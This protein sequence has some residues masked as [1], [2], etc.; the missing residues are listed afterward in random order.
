MWAA[1]K[2]IWAVNFKQRLV[3]AGKKR[4]EIPAVSYFTIYTSIMYFTG[5]LMVAAIQNPYPLEY[6][7]NFPEYKCPLLGGGGVTLGFYIKI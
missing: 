5:V 7:F 1:W 2:D 3:F 6:F 4:F